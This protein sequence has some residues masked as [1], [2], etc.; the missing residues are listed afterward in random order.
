MRS[1]MS[2]RGQ[3]PTAY[4]SPAQGRAFF[5]PSFQFASAV[6]ASP[7]ATI[8]LQA[9]LPRAA[10]RSRFSDGDAERCAADFDI[11]AMP[12]SFFASH[13]CQPPSLRELARRIAAVSLMPR[14]CTPPAAPFALARS[15]IDFRLRTA[16]LSRRFTAPT[17][18]ACRS[19]FPDHARSGGRDR[20]K[21]AKIR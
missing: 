9:F 5:P 14:H 2:A 16:A 15:C 19:A 8:A 7:A 20:Q 3:R 12:L 10:M 13:L 21:I 6:A 4:L 1:L 11:G 18:V 17:G